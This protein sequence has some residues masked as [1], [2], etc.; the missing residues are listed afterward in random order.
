MDGADVRILPYREDGHLRILDIP[1]KKGEADC[2]FKLVSRIL[3][4][5]KPSGQNI[6]VVPLLRDHGF[7]I[8]STSVLEGEDF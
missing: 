6:G 8:E 2:G 5:T 7:L 4:E 1:E 3:Q